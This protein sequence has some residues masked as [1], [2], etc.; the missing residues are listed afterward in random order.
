[1]FSSYDEEQLERLLGSEED[2]VTLKCLTA[3]CYEEM[4][5]KLISEGALFQFLPDSG[6]KVTYTQNDALMILTFWMTNS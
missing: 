1:M 5:N 2:M 4:K 6:K 3:D